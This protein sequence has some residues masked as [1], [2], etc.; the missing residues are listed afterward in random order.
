MVKTPKEFIEEIASDENSDFMYDVIEKIVTEVGPRAPCSE[1]E[2]KA[3]GIVKEELEKFCDEVRLE[4]FTCYPRAF[5]GWIRIV[6]GSM[7]GAFLLVIFLQRF[8]PV[9]VPAI[10]LGLSVFSFLCFYKQFFKYEEWTP[11]FLPYKQGTSQNVVGVIKPSGEVKKRV[12]FSGHLDSAFRFNLINYTGAGYALFFALGV[13][14]LVEATV[15]FLVAFLFGI[16]GGNS[17][18]TV[19]VLDVFILA[20]PAAVNAMVLLSSGDAKL[21]FGVFRNIEWRAKLVVVLYVAYGVTVALLLAPFTFGYDNLTPSRAGVLLFAVNLPALVALF[22]F[23]SKKATP[24]VVDNLSACASAMAVAKIVSGWRDAYPDRFPKQTEVV[25]AIVGCEEVGLRG[26]EAFARRHAAEY[27]EIDTTCVNMESISDTSFVKIYTREDT[28]GTQLSPE[29]YTLLEEC[30]KELDINY[31][32]DHMP[33]IAGG[34]DAAGFV[35]G[36]LKAS[37]LCGLRYRDYLQYYHTDRDNLDI[38]NKERLPW[39]HFGDDWRDYNVRGA[40]EQALC[41]C[42]RYLEKKDAEE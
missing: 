26:S 21:A 36:G 20:V 24:G 28:T 25:V 37:S 23:A 10:C 29:V 16:L 1:E 39:T 14:A 6:V 40:M 7:V 18:Y 38:I 17:P 4:E 13:F 27:S 19:L 34:T 15:L 5:L 35:R 32:V 3:A 33:G 30:A 31:K 2:R 11:K 42:V 9:V 22:F 8:Q 41:I 12:I